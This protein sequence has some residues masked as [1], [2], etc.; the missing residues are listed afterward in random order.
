MKRRWTSLVLAVAL[1]MTATAHSY[2]EGV[3]NI[4]L[5]TGWRQDKVDYTATYPVY[6]VVTG[7][8]T[9]LPFPDVAL[10]PAVNYVQDVDYSGIRS[11]AFGGKVEYKQMGIL[12][13][14]FGQYGIL[15]SGHSSVSS[16][17]DTSA[18]LNSIYN[19]E[20]DRGE[21]FDFGVAAGLPYCTNVW[22]IN[23]T[24]TPLVGWSQHEQHLRQQIPQIIN[25]PS[26]SLL[27]GNVLTAPLL[28]VGANVPHMYNSYQ[29]RWNGV[30]VGYD[31]AIDVPC[32]DFVI[33]QG[34]EWHF[35][36]FQAR[37]Q[38]NMDPFTFVEPDGD[39][40]LINYPGS[41]INTCQKGWGNGFIV[42]AGG[43]W[44]LNRCWTVGILGSYNR[45]WVDN[46]YQD[47]TITFPEA[48]DGTKNVGAANVHWSSWS[49]MATIGFQY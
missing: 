9:P 24:L 38:L 31:L 8:D 15:Y 10:V 14:L 36:H 2:S 45:F 19:A 1:T 13:R 39:A 34:F 17:N 23:L 25:D 4:D 30:F 49:V 41:Q 27:A 22:C 46:I 29:T 33:Y 37:G 35:P 16:T 43:E 47:A 20:S 40:T 3:F 5:G 21:L 11:W 48:F 26:I 32:S 18:V 6:N 28:L 44:Y 42:R 7:L 12:A